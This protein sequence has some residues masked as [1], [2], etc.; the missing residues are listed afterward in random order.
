M[1]CF[2]S[3]RDKNPPPNSC[4]SSGCRD[5]VPASTS[6]GG[7]CLSPEQNVIGS[8]TQVLLEIL[9]H[10]K[11]SAVCK[12][13]GKENFGAGEEAIGERVG[14]SSWAFGNGNWNR[15]EKRKR[16]SSVK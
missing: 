10:V 15:F 11:I 3:R 14:E 13:A 8:G 9:H 4:Q 16:S 5:V 12:E 7:L 1:Q 2:H 6:T